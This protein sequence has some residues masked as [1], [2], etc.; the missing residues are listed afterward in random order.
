MQV[1]KDY[2]QLLGLD[3]SADPDIIDAVYRTLAKKY[4]P[5]TFVGDKNEGDR[6]FRSI[7]HAYQTLS[8]PIKREKYDKIRKDKDKSIISIDKNKNK[9]SEHQRY[10]YKLFSSLHLIDAFFEFH[11]RATSKGEFKRAILGF[12]LVG[13]VFSFGAVII[14]LLIALAGYLD[15]IKYF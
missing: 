11:D 1:D 15:V 13:I 2:Y 5:D 10:T 12:I 3:I 9:L 4:H 7:S 6:I 14:I 8:D